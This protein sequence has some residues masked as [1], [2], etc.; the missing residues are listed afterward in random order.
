ME[1]IMIRL[2]DIFLRFYMF[3]IPLSPPAPVACPAAL[4]IRSQPSSSSSKCRRRWAERCGVWR[5]RVCSR[6]GFPADFIGGELRQTERNAVMS[7][8][9]GLRLR[10]LVSTDLTARGVDVERVNLVLNLDVPPH[11]ETCAPRGTLAPSAR[12]ARW[13]CARRAHA[14]AHALHGRYAHRVGRS[15]RFGTRGLAITLVR[16]CVPATSAPAW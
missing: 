2:T 4:R 11:A 14:H 10:V 8:V 12:F 16:A 7:A 6:H 15:G 13:R 5:V 1:L 3:A 9:R